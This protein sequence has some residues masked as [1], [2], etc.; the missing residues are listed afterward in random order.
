MNRLY[1]AVDGFD[2]WLEGFVDA[3]E[4][5]DPP[6]RRDL[7]EEAIYLRSLWLYRYSVSLFDKEV[8]HARA[9]A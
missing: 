5:A 6:W 9:R 1:I 8:T 2:G 7:V 3:L 4:L